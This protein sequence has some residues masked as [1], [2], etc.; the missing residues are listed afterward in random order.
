MSVG[1]PTMQYFVWTE[2]DSPEKE[3][4]INNNQLNDPVI[5]MR[6]FR[7]VLCK[8]SKTSL[9]S[10]HKR[11]FTDTLLYIFTSGTTGGKA[12]AAIQTDGRM[13]ASTLGQKI[14]YRLKN[15]DILY[16]PFP[17]YH[18]LGGIAGVGLCLIFR[19]DLGHCRKV[20]S[21]RVLEGLH[22]T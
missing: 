14:T 21:V 18:A 1:F 12:K 2:E 5:P 7:D 4:V 9:D 19:S 6:T 22:K 3:N 16:N 15:N 17:L 10:T 8:F 11:N 20:L 13:I